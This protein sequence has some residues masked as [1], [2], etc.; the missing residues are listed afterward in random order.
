MLNS[1][2][3]GQKKIILVIYLFILADMHVIVLECT[4]VSVFLRP[5]AAVMR[6]SSTREMCKC[7]EMQLTAITLKCVTDICSS[8]KLMSEWIFEIK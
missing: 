3:G 6:D 1:A 5:H 4:C 7:G 2:L 8:Y